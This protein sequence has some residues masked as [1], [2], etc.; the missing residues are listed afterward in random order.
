MTFEAQLWE[1]VGWR[2]H[3]YSYGFPTKFQ[4]KM[5]KDAFGMMV[6]DQLFYRGM[7][8]FLVQ[9]VYFD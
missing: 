4:K 9:G 2:I 7:L 3:Y 8:E 1:V 5:A 6:V